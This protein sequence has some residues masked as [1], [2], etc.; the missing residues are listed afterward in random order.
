MVCVSCVDINSLVNTQ[1]NLRPP[2][3]LTLTHLFARKANLLR[4]VFYIFWGGGGIGARSAC[5]CRTLTGFGPAQN[6][7]GHIRLLDV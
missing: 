6:T 4:H 3:L 1:S 2:P 7:V 5:Y